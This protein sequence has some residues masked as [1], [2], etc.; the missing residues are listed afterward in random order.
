MKN[1]I[2]ATAGTLDDHLR[3]VG[4]VFDRLIQAGF[5]V[6][7]SKV[8]LAMQEDIP[9]L[10]FMISKDGVK[11]GASKTKALLDMVCEEMG[12]DPK[13]AARFAG[14]LGFFRSHLQNLH[15]TLAPFHELKQKQADAARIKT[16]GARVVRVRV[17]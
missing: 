16:F 17:L 12:T 8:H 4:M 14:M 2:I 11:P 7:C 9:Y 5:A 3:D 6:K 15:S 10:G 1:V 13:A